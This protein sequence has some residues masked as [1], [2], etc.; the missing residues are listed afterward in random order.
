[1]FC[2][3]LSRSVYSMPE[4]FGQ[5]HVNLNGDQGIFLAVDIFD[6]NIQ[7]RPIKCRFINADGI[8]QPD[9]VQQIPHDFLC[10]IP[11]FRRALVFFTV[12][13]IPLRK[14]ERAILS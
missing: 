11:L 10:V 4:F 9:L 3:Y 1:M 6:L 7:F 8:F 5:Q 12:I 14:A 13:R 2:V